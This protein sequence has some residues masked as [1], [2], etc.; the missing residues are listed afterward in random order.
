[1]P[2]IY[3][4]LTAFNN[5]RLPDMVKHK[6]EAMAENVY[7]FYRGTCHL[8]YEDL[9]STG[10]LPLSPDTWICG[11][12]HLENFGSYKAD[13]RLVYF[14]LNDFD[15]ALLAPCAWDIARMVTSIFIAFENLEIEEEKALK[16]AELFLKNYSG[17]LANGKAF[18][19][20]PR[21]AKGIVCSFLESV[22]KRKQKDLIKKR[23]TAKKH[24]P[25]LSLDHEKHF[26]IEKSL[27]KELTNHVDEWIKTSNKAPGDFKVIDC[28][29]R[30]AGT[31]SLGVKRYLFLLENFNIKNK[32]LLLDMKQAMPSALQ[33]YATINQPKWKDEADRSI[34]IQ[35]RMQ[36]VSVA[37]LDTTQFNGDSFVLQEMQPMEDR[38]NFELI[39][40]RYREIYQVIDDMALL[41]ASRAV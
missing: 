4:R 5:S 7:S 1:M 6:Y 10:G 23:T 16:T 27:K 13:N 30:T 34:Q 12:L 9:H 14:D 35:Q 36:N 18:S 11:D 24:K 39:K 26:Q 28:I 8:F 3:E 33:P 38:I 2:N 17:T 15:E 40:D 32:Y 31:G 25:W 37:L 29:F 22:E 20:D 19:I 21:T 41:T